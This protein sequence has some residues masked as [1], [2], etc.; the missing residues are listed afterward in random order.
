MNFDFNIECSDQ[1]VIKVIDSELSCIE[2]CQFDKVEQSG[3]DGVDVVFYF[4][5]T[6]G[7]TI[8]IQCLTKIILKIIERNNPK[9][10]KFNG[11]ELTGYSKTELVEIIET[12]FGKNDSSSKNK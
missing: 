7:A 2:K 3:F 6:G 11:I 1:E 9:T 5:A 10:F 4:V 12:I 8:F